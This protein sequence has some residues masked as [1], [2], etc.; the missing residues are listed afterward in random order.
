MKKYKYSVRFHTEHLVKDMPLNLLI[1][2]IENQHYNYVL[3]ISY[4]TE[5]Q[6][7]PIMTTTTNGMLFFPYYF[8]NTLK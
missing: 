7:T 3:Q 2:N 8:Y 4:T 5:L 6:R 1:A